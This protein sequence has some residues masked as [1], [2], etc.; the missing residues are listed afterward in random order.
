MTKV[1]MTKVLPYDF[2]ISNIRDWIL[3]ESYDYNK[4]DDITM[5]YDHNHA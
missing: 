2:M 3:V 5:E 4:R 1:S